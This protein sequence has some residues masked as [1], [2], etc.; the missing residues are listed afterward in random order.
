MR[1]PKILVKNNSSTPFLANILVF[2]FCLHVLAGKNAL[3]K[4]KV[5]TILTE[6]F[7]EQMTLYL[8]NIVENCIPKNEVPLACRMG[9]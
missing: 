1:Q 2:I 8:L 9:M 6:Y 4:L 7:W 3:F 5:D